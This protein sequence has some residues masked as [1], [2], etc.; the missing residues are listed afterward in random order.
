MGEF[1]SDD[2]YIYYCGQ[3][4]LRIN[5]VAL[6]VNKSLQNALLGCNLNNNKMIF[7]CFQGK[8]FN[9][10]VIRVYAPT[11]NAEKVETEQFC[12]GLQDLLEL[13]PTKKKKK[14]KKVFS[15]NFNKL[16]T[17]NRNV[18]SHSY[19]SQKSNQF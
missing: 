16:V 4:S 14:K 1:N 9:I 10:T 12:D 18:F 7:V 17:S 3:E 15:V 6:I 11:T 5:R 13:S 2:D 8:Q 19:R